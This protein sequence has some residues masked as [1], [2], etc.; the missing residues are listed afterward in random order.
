[1]SLKSESRMSSPRIKDLL[2]QPVFQ[3]ST[4]SMKISRDS[5]KEVSEPPLLTSAPPPVVQ[6]KPKPPEKPVIQPPTNSN[7]RSHIE[8][9]NGPVV[10]AMSTSVAESIQAVFAAFIWHAGVV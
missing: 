4:T 9:N 8:V 10:E 6:V 5:F 1:M 2:S 7:K 3:M